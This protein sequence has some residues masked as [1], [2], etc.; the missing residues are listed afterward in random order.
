MKNMIVDIIGYTLKAELEK[1]EG[2]IEIEIVDDE[3]YFYRTLRTLARLSSDRLGVKVTVR[4]IKK[5]FDTFEGKDTT[6][7]LRSCI[8]IKKSRIAKYLPSK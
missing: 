4:E 3:V 5:W 7:G 1:V 8:K 2:E 6:H